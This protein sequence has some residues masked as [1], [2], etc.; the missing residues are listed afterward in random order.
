M[1]FHV[2]YLQHTLTACVQTPV[3]EVWSHS[4]AVEVYMTIKSDSESYLAWLQTFLM[5]ETWYAML[6]P[7]N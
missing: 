5:I 1:Q 2:K 7:K 4:P 3:V 6:L